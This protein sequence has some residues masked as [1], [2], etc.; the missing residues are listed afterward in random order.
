M[1]HDADRGGRGAPAV[2]Q[3]GGRDS[4]QKTPRSEE[5]IPSHR[6]PA[7]SLAQL[8]RMWPNAGSDRDRWGR[9]LAGM[10]WPR[11]GPVLAVVALFLAGCADSAAHTSAG[12]EEPTPCEKV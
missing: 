9:I 1:V 5:A 4:D 11:T 6:G 2:C 3:E 7:V 12:G 8:V 10:R